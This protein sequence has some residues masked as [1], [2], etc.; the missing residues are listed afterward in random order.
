MELYIWTTC[1]SFSTNHILCLDRTHLFE[2]ASSFCL[3]MGATHWVGQVWKHIQGWGRSTQTNMK[4]PPNPV[5]ARCVLHLPSN[6]W[7]WMHC[8]KKKRLILD[9][10]EM[11]RQ[12]VSYEKQPQG[13][14]GHSPA[15]PLPPTHLLS[16]CTAPDVHNC[17]TL[18]QNIRSH[19]GEHNWQ[20]ALG[21]V[22]SSELCKQSTT[23]WKSG[24]IMIWIWEKCA[25]IQLR[26]QY[27]LWYTKYT[28]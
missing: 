21:S 8:E 3:R 10:E 15:T 22:A 4:Q 20:L 9:E 7:N 14:W 11:C 1:S 28:R 25:C 16:L 2:A 27:P 12:S 6:E 23:Q 17:P 5:N 26:R 19:P 13:Q 18:H 24:Q